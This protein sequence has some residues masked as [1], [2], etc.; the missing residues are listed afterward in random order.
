MLTG[1]VAGLE[2]L[3]AVVDPYTGER[4]EVGLGNHD[5]EANALVYGNVPPVFAIASVV[6]QVR[7][8]REVGAAPHALNRIAASRLLRHRLLADPSWSARRL[9]GAAPPVASDDRNAPGPAVASGVDEAGRSVVVVCSVGIDLDLVP[10]AADARLA[11]DPAARL[12]LARPRARCAPRDAAD[13]RAARAIPRRS[14][15]SPRSLDSVLERLA[16]LEDEFAAVEAELADPAVL[17][18]PDRLRRAAKRHKDLGA[19][20]S[21]YREYRGRQDDLEAAREMLG[22]ATGDDRES[23][24]A[25]AAEAEAD[26]ER[27]GDELRELLLP[28][29]PNDEKNVIVEIRGAEGGEEANLFARDLFGM[30]E[31]YARTDGMEARGARR[32]LRPTWVGTTRSRSC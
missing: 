6:D 2:V 5:R 21:R 3:R 4:L 24:R 17:A 10:F 18:D 25:E 8:H 26:L 29:D 30:Y 20:V 31:G 14:S 27:L 15:R 1:E 19:I 16:A 9:V 22:E 32:G 28:R 7:S 11:L 13:G 23:M 12:L